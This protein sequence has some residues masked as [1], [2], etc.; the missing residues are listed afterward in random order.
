MVQVLIAY[1]CVLSCPWK[2]I[3]GH[4][5]VIVVMM[6][7]SRIWLYVSTFSFVACMLMLL[8]CRFQFHALSPKLKAMLSCHI[9]SFWWFKF[10]LGSSMSF[11]TKEHRSLGLVCWKTDCYLVM[12]KPSGCQLIWSFRCCQQIKTWRLCIPFKIY[13]PKL[14]CN[15]LDFY[16]LMCCLL[17]LFFPSKLVFHVPSNLVFFPSLYCV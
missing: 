17:L 16:N 10:A 15:D 6:V 5:H 11:S 2:V 12:G 1:L 14:Y 13:V 4:S 9:F 3:F 7:V 8:S